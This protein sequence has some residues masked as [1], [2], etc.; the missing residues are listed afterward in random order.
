MK[1]AHLE[2]IIVCW[3]FWSSWRQSAL[4]VRAL[5]PV[6]DRTS[7]KLLILSTLAILGE[8]NVVLIKDNFLNIMIWTVSHEQCLL[9]A[10]LISLQYL[11]LVAK[12]LK[13][14]LEHSWSYRS[15]DCM[16]F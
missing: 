12:E 6:T 1:A 7:G 10:I 4:Q 15:S 9:G 13:N 5:V 14:L 16:R 11:I 8:L 3:N 2:L